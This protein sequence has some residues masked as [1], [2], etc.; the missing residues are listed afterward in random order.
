MEVFHKRHKEQEA[1]YRHKVHQG[2]ETL[3]KTS[4]VCCVPLVLVLCF[5]SLLTLLLL[6]VVRNPVSKASHCHRL[7]THDSLLFSLIAGGSVA[8]AVVVPV[9]VDGGVAIALDGGVVIA[10][11]QRDDVFV[12]AADTILFVLDQYSFYCPTAVVGFVRC[13]RRCSCCLSLLA[14]CLLP[15]L[16][17][18]LLLLLLPC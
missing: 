7:D 2:K 9:S 5:P 15:L 8:F 16:M 11:A 18:M 6:G 1:D 17:V 3:K 12:V 10:V 14:L 13:C 4:Q